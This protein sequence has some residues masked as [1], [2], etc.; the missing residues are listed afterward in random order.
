MKIEIKKESVVEIENLCRYICCVIPKD[1]EIIDRI[2]DGRKSL[3]KALGIEYN[4]KNEI[5]S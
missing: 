3:C 5:E 2:R 4:I 1:D